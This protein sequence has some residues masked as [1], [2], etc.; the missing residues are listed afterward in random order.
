MLDWAIV[1]TSTMSGSITRPI[2]RDPVNRGRR[3]HCGTIEL[4]DH[5]RIPHWLSNQ[6]LVG[7]AAERSNAHVH[8]RRVLRHVLC[9]QS[10]S[11]RFRTQCA[12]IA[13]DSP[14]GA[15]GGC[16]ALMRYRPISN[17]THTVAKTASFQRFV[18]VISCSACKRCHRA[19]PTPRV[20]SGSF[21]RSVCAT[22]RRAIL[23]N[24]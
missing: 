10:I 17:A 13:A 6:D 16:S 8:T 7:E 21:R 19:I 23:D 5:W 4:S 11:V 24:A 14:G 20:Q 18:G 2:E 22:V 3:F 15:I 9:L 1:C 12:N